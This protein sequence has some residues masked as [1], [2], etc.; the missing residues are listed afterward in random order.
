MKTHY[1]L[2]RS[3]AARAATLA[4]MLFVSASLFFSASRAASAQPRQMNAA[5]IEAAL[6][7]LSVVGSAL[8]VAA[9]PDDENTA[10]LAY[11]SNERAVRTAY[12]SLTRGDGGQNLIGSEKGAMLG[13]VRTQ[14]LLAARRIDGAEQFFTRA[15]DFGFTK[16]PAETLRIWG[17]DDVLADV[18][19]VVRRF[20]PDII[21]TRFPTT[22]EGGHGQHTASAILAAEAFDAAGDPARFPEQLKH[23]SVWRPKRLM[24]NAFSF[25]A[26]PRP[27]EG[28]K[29]VTVDVGT[30]NALLGRSYN[31]I[32]AASRSMHKSQGFGSAERRGSAPNFLETQ[33][34]EVAERDMFDGVDLTWSRIAGGE[35][36]GRLLEEARRT[37]RPAEP[38]AVLPTL[39]AAH[40]EMSKLASDDPLVA[41]KRREL[42]SVIAACAGLWIEAT[43]AEP[44]VTPGGEARITATLVNRSGFPLRLESVRT[45]YGSPTQTAETA[46]LVELKTNQPTQNAFNVRL[47]ETAEPSQP[48]WMKE[49]PGAGLF[50]VADQTLVGS[51]ENAPAVP[52]SFTLSTP[53]GHRLVFETPTLYRWTDRVRGEQY[54]PLVV[55]PRA[56]VALEEGVL[57]FPDGTP[58]RVNV[59]ARTNVAN[60][61]GTLRL[62]LPEGWRAAPESVAVN[63]KDCN[64]ET[65]ASF[66]ITPPANASTAA[67][68]V[69]LSEGGR[70]HA[71]GV[72][73][74]DY[75][76][77]PIQTLFPVAEA[78]L[79]RVNLQRRGNHIGYVMGSGD[80]IPE[81]LRQV[82]YRVTLLSD[83]DLAEADLK[84]FD[85]VVVGVRA[86]NTRTAL[87]RQQTRLLDYVREGGTLVVQYNTVEQSLANF[88]LGPYPFK[89]SQERVTVEEAPVTLLAPQDAL[90]NAPNRITPADFEGWV[91]ER[92][93][94][95]AS[96]WDARYQTLWASRDPGETDKP[97]GT[98]V[99]RYGKGTYIYT[100]YAWFRQLPAG[101]PGAYRLFVNLISA[102]K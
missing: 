38:Q 79:V 86:Y 60:F 5:E 26:T 18:V 41:A 99:A 69:E 76:H 46:A 96:E 85:A 31:E 37:F 27:P 89:L 63:L 62:R 54:R 47:P 74:I 28:R 6:R 32:A 98:L 61:N 15:L 83:E 17:H 11:L 75:Q 65:N 81:A 10:M 53:D 52:V 73:T 55:V 9:H 71:R 25:G 57:V 58:K 12:L 78:R 24:W 3:R 50:R 29:V 19:W 84:T 51:P 21:I 94:Y 22:G 70:V 97:G 16:S 33:K 4:L 13:L 77:I 49:E 95:F 14:E 93:L 30:Y 35:R 39:L 80:E 42:A 43:A 8:Y 34:G 91:Q 7:K 101:V 87:R 1:S 44:Y 68:A 59:R 20:R 48:Y 56:A 45:P 88:Q 67:L 40:A 82:G 36:V 90:L 72:E 2:T 23:V 102:G 92:G 66:T 100:G 64:E